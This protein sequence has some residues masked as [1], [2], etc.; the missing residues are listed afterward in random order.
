[1]PAV[2]ILRWLSPLP[3]VVSLS[4]IFGVQV[5]LANHKNADVNRV[6]VVAGIISLGI[7]GPLIY[8]QGAVGAAISTLIVELC[9][10]SGFILYVTKTGLLNNMK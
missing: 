4:N 9:E 8:S 2:K 3:F 1:M 10:T 6:L 5:M 7:I